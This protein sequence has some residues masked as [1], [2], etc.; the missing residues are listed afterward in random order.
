VGI[1]D[2]LIEVYKDHNDKKRGALNSVVSDCEYLGYNFKLVRGLASVLDSRSIFKSKSAIPPLE[3]RRQVFSLA[4]KTVIIRNE[5]RLAVL[6][7]IADENLISVD[8]LDDSLYSDL[9]EEHYL[10]DFKDLSSEDLSLYY[11]YAHTVAMLAYSTRVELSFKDDDSYLDKLFISLGSEVQKRGS[12]KVVKLKPTNRLSQRAAKFD[13]IMSRLLEK[14]GWLLRA[15]VKYPAR[16]KSTCVFE[17]DSLGDG[18]LL[19][20]DPVEEE[21][22]I[23]IPLSIKKKNRLKYGEIVVLDEVAEREGVT[24]GK[25][26]REIKEEGSE[27]KKLGGVLIVPKKYAEIKAELKNIETLGEAQSY[28]KSHGVRDF[29]Q[30]L[31]SFGYQIEWAKPRKSSRLYRF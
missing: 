11:N 31:E 21:V 13:D 16:Y 29:I 3:A 28:F 26:L 12:M 6:A 22:I 18:R 2:T 27:Y 30:V 1:L 9:E 24:N 23:E 17:I 7:Q 25:V 20:T 5:D 4:N 15:D 8:E 14:E 10:L 19:K